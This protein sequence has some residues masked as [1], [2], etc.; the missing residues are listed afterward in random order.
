MG[1]L[2]NVIALNVDN[3]DHIDVQFPWKAYRLARRYR[4]E[5]GFKELRD[6]ATEA[7]TRLEPLIG[8]DFA[9]S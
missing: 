8:L 3:L 7:R 9:T 2:L 4:E 5:L 6:K 1:C